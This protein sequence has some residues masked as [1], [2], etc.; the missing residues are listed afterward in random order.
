MFDLAKEWYDWQKL[1]FVFAVWAMKKSLSDS[2]KD[3]LK[4]I[5]SNSLAKSEEDLATIG[6]LHGRQIALTSEETQEYL[7]GFNYRLG[8]REKEAMVKFREMV[9]EVKQVR[10]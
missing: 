7:A 4:Y 8:E 6:E 5:L 1:P 3:E 9:E 2:T 10:I